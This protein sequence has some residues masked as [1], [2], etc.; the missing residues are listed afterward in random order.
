[1]VKPIK[2]KG[3]RNKILKYHK[4]GVFNVIHLFSSY[5]NQV[6]QFNCHIFVYFKSPRQNIF[7]GLI[8]VTAHPCFCIIIAVKIREVAD[9]VQCFKN[10]L[11][12]YLPFLSSYHFPELICKWSNPF[13]TQSLSSQRSNLNQLKK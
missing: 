10:R 7:F 12:L 6:F 13:Q 3:T 5:R 2:I 1:M 9:P 11:C 4:S 8:E